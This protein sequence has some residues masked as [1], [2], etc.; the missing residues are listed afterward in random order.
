[1]NADGGARGTGIDAGRPAL[2]ARAH[3]AL[4]RGFRLFG[5]STAQQAFDK[6]RAHRNFRHVYDAVRAVLLALSATDAGIIDE[7]F[8][9]QLAVNRIGGTVV[10]AMRVLA[11]PAR[12]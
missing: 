12:C 6:A 9:V 3:V 11:M 4:D 8:T 2:Q 7:Y 1:M 5:G 10:H